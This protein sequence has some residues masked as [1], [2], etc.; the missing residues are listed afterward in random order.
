MEKNRQYYSQQRA[1]E[2]SQ[3][4][5]NR[6][7]RDRLLYSEQRAAE[8]SQEREARTIIKYEQYL[9]RRAAETLEERSAHLEKI[10]QQR[11][12]RAASLEM[13]EK[14]I[15]T[16]CNRFC[17]IC[18]KRCYP[19][20]V[21]TFQLGTTKPAYLPDELQINSQL[22]LCHRCKTHVS[23]QKTTAP[24]KAY[25]NKLDPGIIPNE[26]L[27]LSQTTTIT[28]TYH[29]IRKNHQV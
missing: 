10:R 29:T 28:V 24:S 27:V 17:E 18:T 11:H 6:L 14:D 21:T 1:A 15:N 3:E 19:N 7:A 20:Q 8:T 26:I 5:E 9:H 16:F 12:E 25:W 2:T 13:F 4:R 22:I 23:S